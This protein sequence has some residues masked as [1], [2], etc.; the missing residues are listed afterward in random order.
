MTTFGTSREDPYGVVQWV[1][2]RLTY[3]I[4]ALEEHAQD[5]ADVG[6]AAI[7]QQIEGMDR[8]ADPHRMAD[9]DESMLDGIEATYTA[10]R[11]E[12]SVN[13]KVGWDLTKYR[14]GYPVLQDMGFM[15]RG[16]QQV[17][18]M[19]AIALAEIAMRE[20]IKKAIEEGPSQ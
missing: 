9:G 3:P 10:S 7:V 17:V 6:Q 1:K 4:R 5:I 13:I 16:G 11:V 15:G 8:I 18:G 12:N 20:A 19:Q 14:H 2:D